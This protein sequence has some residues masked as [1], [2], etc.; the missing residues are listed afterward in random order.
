LVSRSNSESSNNCVMGM[1]SARFNSGR[2]MQRLRV[3]RVTDRNDHRMFQSNIAR[4]KAGA[5]RAP[6]ED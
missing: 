1:T 3:R 5:E 4:R 6:Q 2:T